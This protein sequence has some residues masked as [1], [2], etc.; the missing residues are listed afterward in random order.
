MLNMNCA[1]CSSQYPDGAK[2]CGSCGEKVGNSGKKGLN[3]KVNKKILFSIFAGI[4]VFAL[5]LPT[6]YGYYRTQSVINEARE[7]KLAGDYQA[8]LAKLAEIEA[9]DYYLTSWQKSEAETV[10]DESTKYSE[11]QSSFD[12]ASEFEK[13]GKF[14]DARDA[15]KSIGE[16]FPKYSEVRIKL[17]AVQTNIETGL[18]KEASD[19]AAKAAKAKAD[20]IAA[21]NARQSAKAQADALAAQKAAAD[22]RAAAS[23]QAARDAEIEK[24][25]QVQ[26]SFVNQLRSIYVQYNGD[27]KDYYNDAMGYY[28]NGSD[29]TALAIFGQARALFESAYDNASELSDNFTGLPSEYY[30]AA[31]NMTWAAY[32]MLKATDE[33]VSAIGSSS[34]GLA[35]YY[36]SQASTYGSKVVYFLNNY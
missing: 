17:D 15:L 29:Y 4:F 24:T 31:V 9:N 32:Y 33:M 11:Y 21:E 36:S 23:A 1:N 16:D 20:A 13:K 26:I 25:K 27:G 19:A 12:K 35:N 28:N 6:A 22:A 8:S 7:L 34:S 10:R 3:F 14:E 30:S 5:G 2:F 18:K